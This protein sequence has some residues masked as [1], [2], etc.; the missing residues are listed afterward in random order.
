MSRSEITLNETSFDKAE[1]EKIWS[2]VALV[3]SEEAAE[4]NYR[5]LENK[6]NTVKLAVPNAS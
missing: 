4:R 1:N 6:G 2:S 5:K 3:F